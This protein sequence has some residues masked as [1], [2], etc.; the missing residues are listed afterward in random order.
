MHSGAGARRI[1]ATLAQWVEESADAAELADS[2]CSVWRGVAGALKPI[3]GQRG[4]EA[5]YKRSLHLAQQQQPGLDF[6]AYDESLGIDDFH[7]LHAALA[8]Q[9]LADA[10]LAS[11]E[12]LRNFHELLASLI[13]E[14]LTERLLRSALGPPPLNSP[15]GGASK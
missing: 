14:A 1:E 2:T 3:V 10:A 4:F 6:G 8:R 5:L 7:P 11:S 12:L 15:S 13:G 9:T